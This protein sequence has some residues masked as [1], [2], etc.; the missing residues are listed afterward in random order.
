MLSVLRDRGAAHSPTDTRSGR[1][2]HSALVE[3]LMLRNAGRRAP[4]PDPEP[5]RLR[6]AV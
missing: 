1:T 4:V 6:F 5:G 2:G 3:R